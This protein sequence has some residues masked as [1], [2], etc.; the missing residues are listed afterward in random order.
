MAG[1][2]QER[3][4]LVH[5][6]ADET[7]IDVIAG[8]ALAFSRSA[9][10]KV[11]DAQ[12]ATEEE[13][14]EASAGVV[15][16]VVRSLQSYQSVEGGGQVDRVYLAGGTGL[17]ARVAKGLSER[18]GVRCLPLNPA[19]TMRLGGAGGGGSEFV[20]AL[21]LAVGHVAAPLDFL[22]PKRPAA[23]RHV[24]RTRALLG[25]AAAI[26]LV[27]AS[28]VL[29]GTY[30]SGKKDR[31]HRL[32]AEYRR[33]E[34][35]KKGMDANAGRVAS[36][37]DWQKSGQEWLDHFALLSALFPS[38]QEAYASGIIGNP[39][40]TLR[41]TLHAANEQAVTEITKQLGEAGYV[42]KAGRQ[43]KTNDPKYPHSAEMQ[44]Q[45][46]PSMTV[47]LAS[48]EAVP[49]PEDD[50]GAGETLPRP[51]PPQPANPNPAGGQGGLRSLGPTGGGNTQGQPRNPGGGNPQGGQGGGRGVVPPG[52]PNYNPNPPSGGRDPNRM[53][54][55]GGAR[56]GQG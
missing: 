43:S 9:L 46:G 24:R 53:R 12:K 44:V 49:R 55:F 54:R 27:V 42:A 48:L 35:R 4:A 29:G 52:N 7:E 11:P 23:P 28:V 31:V 41:F 2:S 1:A 6:T 13:L 50:L 16:E 34:A 40:G 25:S 36:I 32:Q 10:G 47:D 22:A 30:L 56:G 45:A 38:A 39:D 51:R 26:A 15:T 3:C 33:L 14:A 21:G 5:L 19:E 17:E 20:T 18:L 37:E 8:Q